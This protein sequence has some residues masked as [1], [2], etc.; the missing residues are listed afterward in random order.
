MKRKIPYFCRMKIADYKIESLHSAHQDNKQEPTPKSRHWQMQ[1]ARIGFQTLGRIFPT[2]MAKQAYTMFATPRWRAQHTRTDDIIDSARVIDFNFQEHNIKLYEWGNPQNPKILLAHGWESR[3]TAL[4]M[5]VPQLLK[6]GYYIIAY[7]AVGHGDSSGKLNNISTNAKTIAAIINHYGGIY[8]AIGHSFG[9][10][11]LVYAMQYID[12]SISIE[13]LVFL[14]VPHKTKKIIDG[15]FKT[16]NAPDGV[17]KSF[18]SIIEAANQRSLDEIDVA[19][20]HSNVKVGKLLLLH[21][22]YDDVTSLE[23]AENV[24]HNWDNAKL[25]ITEGYGHFRIAKNPD[26]MKRIIEFIMEP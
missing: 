14:A 2:W 9:C 5:F 6:L 13:K 23:A 16:V 15:F 18:Y 3:G 10:S 24:V 1:A 7:D 11:S 20:A 8:G 25:L 19:T 22:R 17:K 4:R 21:D 12:N 26:V